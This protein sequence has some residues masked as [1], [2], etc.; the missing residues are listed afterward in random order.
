MHFTTHG[1]TLAPFHLADDAPYHAYFKRAEPVVV[2]GAAASGV[3]NRAR[4]DGLTFLDVLW[5][6]APFATSGRFV[7]GG[8]R[9]R[10]RMAV[11]GAVQPR[12]AGRGR[13]GRRQRGPQGRRIG[14]MM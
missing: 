5:G 4:G 7:P 14:P 10:R 11:R 13:R 1:L 3:P 6:Q 8:A 12:R 2:F 9:P